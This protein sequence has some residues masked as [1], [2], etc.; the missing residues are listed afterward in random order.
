LGH[1]CQV[2]R[3][4][5]CDR[6]RSVPRQPLG[7]HWS[8]SRPHQ[9]NEPPSIVSPRRRGKNALSVARRTLQWGW[10]GIGQPD[11]DLALHSRGGTGSNLRNL[12]PLRPERRWND[13]NGFFAIWVRAT[14][15]RSLQ[16]NPLARRLAVPESHKRISGHS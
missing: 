7:S 5:G 1:R 10:S 8:D 13:L 3:W 4:D 2:G 11:K 16:R 9:S 14:R 15:G 6:A 12:S